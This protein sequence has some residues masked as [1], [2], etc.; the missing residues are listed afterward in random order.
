MPKQASGMLR[1][2]RSKLGASDNFKL[3]VLAIRLGLI[4]L[5]DA[6]WERTVFLRAV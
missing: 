2:L 5:D 1:N 3:A 4:D 6:Q